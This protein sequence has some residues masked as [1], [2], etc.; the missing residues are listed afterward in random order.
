MIH[1]DTS[2]LVRALVARSREDR[3]LREWL[4]ADEP[5]AMSCIGWAGFLCGP[6]EPRHVELALE[7]V[8]D[9]EPFDRRDA[10]LAAGLFNRSGRRR[11]TLSD[12]MIA[13][14]ALRL[15]G[16]LATANAGDFRRFAPAG[17]RILTA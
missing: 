17:L 1:L 8:G 7:I 12:C 14:S 9:P 5:L 2:F 11:G 6:V 10:E 15:G 3:R 4:R 13:A 16:S